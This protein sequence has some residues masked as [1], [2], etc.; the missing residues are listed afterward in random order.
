MLKV[1][2][3]IKNTPSRLH[4]IHQCRGLLETPQTSKMEISEK[5]GKGHSVVNCFCKKL[6]PRSLAWFLIY[7]IKW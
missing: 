1:E 4:C 7:V 2:N 3:L 5:N 6:R